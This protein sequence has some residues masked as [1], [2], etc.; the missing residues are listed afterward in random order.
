MLH[1]NSNDFVPHNSRSPAVPGVY[2]GIDL[3]GQK[4][5]QTMGIWA[6]FYSGDDP[7]C[8][9]EGVSTFRESINN[10][11]IHHLGKFSQFEVFNILKKDRVFNR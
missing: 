5:L 8:R 7:G 1:D 6:V 4:P 10:D 11:L 9:T 3:D 2:R